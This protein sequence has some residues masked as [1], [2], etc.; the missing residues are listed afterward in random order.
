MPPKEISEAP[1]TDA[2]AS[3]T[4]PAKETS[5]RPEAS[6]AASKTSALLDDLGDED[7]EEDDEDFVSIMKNQ[8]PFKRTA[9]GDAVW[10]QLNG[11]IR[12]GQRHA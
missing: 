1:V 6:T 9:Q 8:S 3:T 12:F 2:A 4:A 10:E 11:K 7:D 5:S